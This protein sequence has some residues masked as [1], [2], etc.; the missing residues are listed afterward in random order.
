MLGFLLCQYTFIDEVA[1]NKVRD[2]P[3]TDSVVFVIVFD[4]L[5]D[6]RYA[7]FLFDCWKQLQVVP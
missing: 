2:D 4:V 6:Q 3:R 5:T 1:V 7:I